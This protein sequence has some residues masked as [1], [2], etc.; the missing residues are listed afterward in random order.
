MCFALLCWV[1]WVGLDYCMYSVVLCCAVLVLRSLYD[2]CT[3]LSLIVVDPTSLIL[4]RSTTYRL[5]HTTYPPHLNDS[6][7]TVINITTAVLKMPGTTKLARRRQ[8]GA[9]L[10]DLTPNA[11]IRAIVPGSL[12][13][14]WHPAPALTLVQ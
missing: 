10:P 11:P 9:A 12:P 1:D 14:H 6:I 13:W 7:N 3:P 2:T 5:P 8:S 4:I